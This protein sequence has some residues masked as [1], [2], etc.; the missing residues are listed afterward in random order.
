[1]AKEPNKMTGSLVDAA[2]KEFELVLG[3]KNRTEDPA[4]R[5]GA[6]VRKRN[7][8]GRGLSALMSSNAL[9]VEAVPGETFPSD[10]PVKS[11]PIRFESA[12]NSPAAAEHAHFAAPSGFPAAIPAG[13]ASVADTGFVGTGS[14]G[15]GS[16]AEQTAAIATAAAPHAEA[17]NPG[18]NLKAA[19]LVYVPIKQLVRN[20]NQPRQHFSEEELD[21]LSRSIRQTGLLQPILVRP[22]GASSEEQQYEII[23]G[24][25]RYRAAERA[26]LQ[27]IPALVRD[28][29]EREVLEVSIVENVQRSQLNAIEEARA[30]QRLADEFH[31]AQD[32]IAKTVGKDRTTIAN[33]LR[34][35]KLSP[36]VQ[37]LLAAGK[38]SAG[39]ARALLMIHDEAAQESIAEEI[40]AHGLS[41]RAVEMR[42]RVVQGNRSVGQ[43]GG[44]KPAQ[45]NVVS[46]L[47]QALEERFRRKLGTKVKLQ[48]SDAGAGELRISFFS[49]EELEKLVELLEV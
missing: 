3:R 20:P 9:E 14:A 49:S 27:A 1:M 25:R 47:V 38:L 26:G 4:F 22:L 16:I 12:G 8:L 37:E 18:S 36:K 35:L 42:A 31:L 21:D 41:V 48:V 46:P 5:K 43:S 28:L 30:Y 15:T 33:A 17:F 39:H 24:E 7:A 29:D 19:G 6:N 32:E 2:V 40:I 44:D 23:A 13:P 10:T 34:L 11:D 45:V